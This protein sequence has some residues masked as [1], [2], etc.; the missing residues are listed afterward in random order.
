MEDPLGAASLSVTGSSDAGYR[1][2]VSNIGSSGQDGVDI[3]LP[4]S[5]GIALTYGG[6][7]SP[8]GAIIHRDLACRGMVSGA[9]ATLCTLNEDVG[10]AGIDLGLSVDGSPGLLIEAWNGSSLVYSR[11]CPY[12]THV[13]LGGAGIAVDEQ[14]VHVQIALDRDMR[15]GVVSRSVHAVIVR[16]SPLSVVIEGGALVTADRVDLRCPLAA[17]TTRCADALLRCASSGG[18]AQVAISDQGLPTKNKGIRSREVSAHGLTGV[19]F[20]SAS[21]SSELMKLLVTHPASDPDPAVI[22]LNGLPPGVPWEERLGVTM[23]PGYMT[24]AGQSIE[25]EARVLHDDGSGGP[26][27]EFSDRATW[28]SSDPG[29]DCSWSWGTSNPA[30]VATWVFDRGP[31][32][33]VSL[34]GSYSVVSS[35]PPRSHAALC[36]DGSCRLGFGFAPGVVLTANGVTIDADSLIVDFADPASPTLGLEQELWHLGVPGVTFPALDGGSKEGA[37]RH[38][39]LATAEGNGTVTHDA[40]ERRLPVRNLGSSGEDGVSVDLQREPSCDEQ[41]PTPLDMSFTYQKVEWKLYTCDDG[42]CPASAVLRCFGAG[43]PHPQF[44]VSFAAQGSNPLF[45][46]AGGKIVEY[47]DCDSDGDGLMDLFATGGSPVSIARVRYR[48]YSPYKECWNVDLGAPVRIAMSGQPKIVDNVKFWRNRGGK[49]GASQS[50]PLYE[51]MAV[52]PAGSIGVGPPL[53]LSD[54]GWQSAGIAI[55]DPGVNG[56]FAGFPAVETWSSWSGEGLVVADLDRDGFPDLV[57]EAM[58]GVTPLAGT[59]VELASRLHEADP[60]A[61]RGFGFAAGYD[62]IPNWPDSMSVAMSVSGVAG[63]VSHPALASLVVHGTGGSMRAIQCDLPGMSVSSCDLYLH[64][65][66]QATAGYGSGGVL[67]DKAPPV[68]LIEADVDGDGVLEPIC[69]LPAGSHVLA[70]GSLVECDSLVFRVALPAAPVTDVSEC[71]VRLNGLPPGEPVIGTK[72]AALGATHGLAGVPGPGMAPG[73]ALSRA[74]PNPSFGMT[75][76]GLSLPAAARVRVSVVD[77]SG[78]VVARVADG[79]FA[80]GEHV[81]RWDGRREDGARAA[82]GVYFVRVERAGDGARLAA[83]VAR[84]R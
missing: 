12:G 64:G 71:T 58:G 75:Q 68:L 25:V 80:A 13:T 21:A 63:G 33:T 6:T 11:P 41:F 29:L 50:N 70:G 57:R 31:R 48:Q 73:F 28:S 52:V 36:A 32:Q 8:K 49:M 18:G 46:E 84:V 66:K 23:A 43:Q 2:L 22:S 55:G 42:S 34:D 45:V 27:A 78:R 5:N 69:R 81:L 16:P 82:A 10:P 9:L 65:A 17:G 62:S 76:V 67:V 74:W 24:A 26:P 56:N 19:L 59:Q 7:G 53:A 4:G 1:L 77:V 79:S 14:G 3:T 30:A 61:H 51:R 83:R 54:P 40:V 37:F 39:M 72:L 44:D 47:L 35:A 38:G 15:D 20:D 60:S